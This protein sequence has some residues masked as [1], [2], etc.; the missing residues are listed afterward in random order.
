M[1]PADRLLA[2]PALAAAVRELGFASAGTLYDADALAE[3][4]E[5]YSEGVR[6]FAVA[7]EPYTMPT[8]ALAD[9]EARTWFSDGVRS[10][11]TRALSSILDEAEAMVWLGE[12]SIKPPGPGSRL[13]YHQ[14][15]CV[16]DEG[17]YRCLNTWA[18]L[19]PS[20]D[21]NGALRF[22]PGSHLLPNFPR[23]VMAPTSFSR[24]DD[25]LE[26]REVLVEAAPGEVLVFDGCTLH[27]SF[28]NLTDE[29]RV[30]VRALVRPREAPL[31]FYFVDAS[32]PPGT[33]EVFEVG[34][35]YW[36][37]KGAFSRPVEGT[38]A[39]LGTVSWQNLEGAD[40]DAAVA[41]LPQAPAC[42]AERVGA[43]ARGGRLPAAEHFASPAVQERFDRHGFVVLPFLEPKE[44]AWLGTLLEEAKASL[45]ETFS[46]SQQGGDA[47][48]R[49]AVSDGVIALT[50]RAVG[51][52][53]VEVRPLLAALL[54]T[55]PG[56]DS[57]ASP[58]AGWTVVDERWSYSVTVWCPLVDTDEASGMLHLMA[59]SH[60]VGPTLRG[61]SLPDPF[62][63]VDD[64]ALARRLLPVS[65]RAGEAIVFDN[66]L[67]HWAPPN[68]TGKPYPV[69]VVGLCP[70]DAVPIHLEAADD[71][72]LYRAEVDDSFFRLGGMYEA[73]PRGV[74]SRAPVEALCPPLE[75]HHLPQR[76][77]SWVAK[78]ITS[79]DAPGR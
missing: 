6:R 27:R 74:R 25:Q 60:R 10:I 48:I 28:P 20:T 32:T 3:L 30:A 13:G 22:V 40:L 71:G 11:A 53:F 52:H 33:A 68:Q 8:L 54:H 55:P 77:P 23:L 26:P 21:A 75:L 58:R 37:E 47:S 46:S 2:V 50:R 72:R 62:E 4:A 44:L 16:T 69:A 51:E 56:E 65:C 15:A 42:E 38:A 12:F 36:L 49:R 78:P 1:V 5:L 35:R 64:A 59:G 34:E 7:Q 29:P 76:A 67:V 39:P 9:P 41:K 61:P 24:A 66:R 79:R 73:T 43:Q 19:I 63:N 45:G 18:S 57:G 31:R 14:D 17:R 70:R